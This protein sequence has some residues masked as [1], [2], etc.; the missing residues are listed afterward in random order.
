M[1]ASSIALTAITTV[2]SLLT[3]PLL[4]GLMLAENMPAD[5]QMP[6]GRVAYDITVALIAPL[7]AGMLLGSRLPAERRQRYSRWS[8]FASLGVILLMVIGGAG[9][10]RID[11]AA[12]GWIAPAVVFAMALVFTQM[13]E[14]ATRIGGLVEGDRAAVCIEVTLR[15]TN[16]AILV[17]ASVFPAVAGIADG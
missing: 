7:A 3:T 5:F 13:A 2:G 15:N 4:L 6:T 9:A 1:Q 17:K 11:P 10:G 14:L 16:L 8:I 12:H